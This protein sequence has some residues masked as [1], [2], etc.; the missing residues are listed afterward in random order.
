MT[1]ETDQ[2]RPARGGVEMVGG[3]NTSVAPELQRCTQRG[4]PGRIPAG[5]RCP[6]HAAPRGFWKRSPYVRRGVVDERL[7]RADLKKLATAR[8]MLAMGYDSEEIARI[9]GVTP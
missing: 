9:L 7:S 8:R 3:T 4:C 6:L 1:P 5:S 2:R